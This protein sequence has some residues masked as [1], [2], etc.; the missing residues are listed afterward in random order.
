M[1]LVRRKLWFKASAVFT[2]S[3]MLW[4]TISDSAHAASRDAANPRMAVEQVAA[5]LGVDPST[6]SGKSDSALEGRVSERRRQ[7][8]A[9][10]EAL[11]GRERERAEVEKRAAEIRRAHAPDL[12]AGVARAAED[13]RR[14]ATERTSSREP[15]TQRAAMSRLAAAAAALESTTRRADVLGLGDGPIAGPLSKA[16]KLAAAAKR[17]A[18][19]EA[20]AGA[21]EVRRL[22]P[23]RRVALDARSRQPNRPQRLAPPAPRDRVPLGVVPDAEQRTFYASL[24]DAL[25]V[26]VETELGTV[27]PALIAAG[28]APAPMLALAGPA[29][30]LD[31]LLSLAAGALPPPGAA[32]LADGPDARM[33]PE[34]RDAAAALSGDP[35]AIYNF[36][37]D[38]FEPEPYF[39]SKKGSVGAWEERAG[40][41]ADLSSLLVAMLRAA[42][43]PARYEYG[44]VDLTAEQAMAWTGTT[45][46]Y[47]A[48]DAL[49]TG[50]I[51]TI[52]V[53]R[54]TERVVRVEH[55]WVRAWVPY[56]NYR[57]VARAGSR[58]L[59]VRLDPTIQQARLRPATNVRGKVIFDYASFLAQVGG[60]TPREVFEGQLRAHAQANGIPCRS[61]DDFIPARERIPDQ[62]SLLPAEL[63]API[64]APLATFAGFPAWMRHTASLDLGGLQAALPLPEIYGL[65]LTVRYR[66]ATASHEAAI[67]AAG[68]IA[69]LP[70]PSAVRVVPTLVVDG[71]ERGRGAAVIPGT[72]QEMAVTVASPHDATGIVRHQLYAG[73]VFAV[74]FPVGKVPDSVVQRREAELSQAVLAGAGG[75]D[76]EAA[77]GN[78]ALWRYFWHVTRDWERI[79]GL[80]WARVGFGVSEG[81]A[82]RSVVAQSLYDVPVKIEPGNFIIDVPRLV[83]GPYSVD[84]R[85]RDRIPTVFELAGYESSTREHLIWEETVHFPSI[86]TVRILQASRQQ[87]QQ[88]RTLTAADAGMVSTLPFSESAREDIADALHRGLVVTIAERPVTWATYANAEGYVLKDPRTG[89]A[90]FRIEGLYSGGASNGAGDP[91]GGAGFCPACSGADAPAASRVSLSDGAM[92]FTETDLS[93]PARGIP[94]SFTRRYNSRSPYGGRLGAGWQHTYEGRLVLEP[95]GDITY[96]NDQLEPQRFGRAED[97]SYVA[98]AGFHEQLFTLP[99][100]YRLVFNDGVE[101]RFQADGQLL[102][103]QDP[104]DHV[105]LLRYQ[106]GRLSTVSDSTGRTVLTFLYDELGFLESVSD[107][108]GR[109][110]QF[111]VQAGN[112]VAVTDV[113]NGVQQYG[114]DASHR[115]TSKTDR[116]GHATFEFYDGA[117]RW[118]GSEDPA[119][120][121][122]AVSYDALNRRAL[123]E[124]KAGAITLHEY[125]ARG[126]PVAVTDALGN[127]RELRWDDAHH[128][129][130]E[131]DA[132]GNE[133]TFSYDG[134][135]NLLSRTDALTGVTSYTYGPNGRVLTVTTGG[136]LV[137]ENTYDAQGRLETAIDALRKVTRYAYTPD[138]LPGAITQP[139]SAITAL[140][141]NDDGTVRSITDPE[142]GTTT[143]GYD[144]N[145]HLRSVKDAN[146]KERTLVA[147]AAGRIRST[148]DAIQKTTTFE[149]DPEGNRTAVVDAALER[150]EF[151]YD[152][153]NRLVSVTDATG[154]VSRTDYDPEDRAISRSDPLGRTTRFRYDA[155]GRLVETIDAAGAVASQGYC[156]DVSTQACA[157]VDPLGNLTEV[158]FDAVG[159]PTTTTDASGRTTI[160]HYDALGRRERTV[161]AGQETLYAYDDAGRLT[162][163]TDALHGAT[164]YGYDD[165]GNR[166]SVTDANLNTT[167]FGYDKA[168]RLVWERNPVQAE[169]S[170][171]RYEY[172]AAGNRRFKTDGN[173]W[174]TEYVY[175][176]NRRLTNVLFQDGTTYEFAY[177]ARGNRTLEKSSTHERGLAYDEL[178][179]L[180]RVEDRTLGRVITYGY[181]A[182]GQRREMQVDTGEV[183]RYHWDTLGRLLE[184]TDPQGDTT[185]FGYD[186]AGRR[187]SA[188]YG[189]GT[190]AT[191]GY[192]AIGQV[193][194]VAYLDRSG[195]VQTAFGYGYDEAGNRTHKAFGDGT[196]ETYGYDGLNR[197]VQVDYPSGR[198]VEYGYDRVG[199]RTSLLDGQKT[200][201]TRWA[202]SATASAAMDP[203]ANATGTPDSWSWATSASTG[204]LETT[205]GSASRV[206]AVRV[207]EV[208]GAPLVTR[209][210]LIEESGASHSVYSGGDRTPQV[211]WLVVPVPLTPYRVKKVKVYA[212]SSAASVIRIDAV[213]LDGPAEE[214][215]A[216]NGFN[217][218][219]AVNAGDGAL[220]TFGYDGNGNQT[221]KAVRAGWV[222]QRTTYGYD[223]DNRLRAVTTPLAPAGEP[224][225]QWA[226][227]ATASSQLMPSGSWTAAQATGAP[228]TNGCISSGQA[229]APAGT[230]TA[231]EWLRVE[232]ATPVKSVGVKVHETS[233]AGSVTRVEVIDEGGASHEVWTGQ[234]RTF[235][236][237]WLEV[238]FPETAYRVMAVTL[239][240]GGVAQEQI[241]AVGLVSE[242]APTGTLTSTYEYDA[243]GLRTYKSDSAGET[244]YLLDGLS[245]VAQYEPSGER[246]AWYTQ[247][248]ARIDEVLSVVNEQGKFWYQADALGSIYALTT[249]AGDVRA[250]GG[251]DVFGEAVA[252]GGTSVGQPFG[253]SGREHDLDGALV[254]ARDRYLSTSTGRWTQ[255]DRFAFADGPNQYGYVRGDPTNLRD[256][257]GKF[258]SNRSRPEVP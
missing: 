36:V 203:A 145:G 202:T 78:R 132:R 101:Y 50:G 34:I 62:L 234:D 32:D 197:L 49:A 211:G 120:Y 127:R 225:V 246:Q 223:A 181:D 58:A 33:T 98:P 104:S 212:G 56:S 135:G 256:P 136:K 102:A 25:D 113:L 118:I 182:A 77:R 131:R 4:F 156:A 213:G 63:P 143:L 138:G 1:L 152:A 154:A 257:S 110:V 48:G 24:L 73:S 258:A 149:Y 29:S 13:A 252:M 241:D 228:N 45:D 43:I 144:A 244:R 60:Q 85:E 14:A 178:G 133:T 16:R 163:V 187:T 167:R 207:H 171:T 192:D 218:L 74:A 81:I 23:P 208:G 19:S 165:R 87:G 37:H 157:F 106:S 179:R 89:G 164:E 200:G 235:C 80:E 119:G 169:G 39:G 26:Q 125:N 84:G 71:V 2:A 227:S 174:R 249:A 248:L 21:E 67:T 215:Y 112:L 41:D 31:A 108:A 142:G 238:K 253:F 148:T 82:G 209:I 124:D 190:R 11:T 10:L 216:Y 61:L 201:A 35:I 175:D 38:G 103:I 205:Y 233:G 180:A 15:V 18:R 231:P 173:G 195:Q 93:V 128:K 239:S 12:L 189:N 198:H 51:P 99:D 206:T 141:Y 115:M 72:V 140:A 109:L 186:A 100:G 224:L 65:S 68:G 255:A 96:V 161:S 147:D 204:W 64:H 76:V 159:R 191:Y 242:P 114:Y 160:E 92:Y 27:D 9:R 70:Q 184:L 46:V 6:I 122:R 217:Q 221:S 196:K 75:D 20:G 155:V 183:T 150:T 219:L 162:K 94:V 40:N 153:L 116:N 146:L 47:Q 86:S 117:G 44:T 79:F 254:Y 91:P 107:H 130:W 54:G 193:L 226:S 243:N 55:V 111:D 134:E 166:V 59:W 83:A 240:T 95:G 66:G 245:V 172:D 139:G 57:G 126:N 97:G 251:Y 214:T 90:D 250:R 230:S 7:A 69:Q 237:E 129:V 22:A 194:S 232:Y 220:T 8:L 199:N 105:V 17:A 210:D 137:A 42:G 123:H 177:D 170:E 229:W 247:S 121:G 3:S 5:Q 168:N 158:Q 53:D 185:R 236:G 188:T 88:V 176:A 52:V 222:T 151:A 30:D 28:I